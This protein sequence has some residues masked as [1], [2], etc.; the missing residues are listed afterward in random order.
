MSTCSPAA[1][2]SRPTRATPNVTPPD[3]L[4]PTA[5]DAMSGAPSAVPSGVRPKSRIR[6]LAGPAT[7][8]AAVATNAGRPHFFIAAFRRGCP[9]PVRLVRV[10]PAVVNVWYKPPVA[11]P[12]WAPWR[13]E[14]VGSA[15]EQSGCVFCLAAEG[16][17]EQ[18]L[19]IHR[20]ERAFVLL[21]RF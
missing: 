18:G 4:L 6:P 7:S 10:R 12:L 5:T 19:V 3:A 20:A 14:Y 16:D 13:L 17:D 15:D 8:T 11:K 1:M 21:N 2:S 9:A